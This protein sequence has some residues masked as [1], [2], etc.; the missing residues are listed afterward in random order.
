MES[1]FGK[2]GQ[3]LDSQQSL[4]EAAKREWDPEFDQLK[5]SLELTKKGEPVGA[6]RRVEATMVTAPPKESILKE[7]PPVAPT[8]LEEVPW[9]MPENWQEAVRSAGPPPGSEVGTEERTPPTY[10]R[11]L[12]ALRDALNRTKPTPS[13]RIAHLR[14]D[15]DICYVHDTEA[16]PGGSDELLCCVCEKSYSSQLAVCIGSSG[17]G[18]IGVLYPLGRVVT[19]DYPAAYTRLIEDMPA[20]PFVVADIRRPAIL[21]KINSGYSVKQKLQWSPPTDQINRAS[22]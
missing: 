19:S 22:V 17:Q 6:Q 2:L 16:I 10:L 3:I 4:H 13:A 8:G 18:T 14:L 5:L 21:E 1:L 11:R 7:L 15:G 12:E 9:R 20:F